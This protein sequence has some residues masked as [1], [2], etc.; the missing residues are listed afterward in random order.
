MWIHRKR[1]KSAEMTLQRHLIALWF[2]LKDA[3]HPGTDSFKGTVH[4]TIMNQT[5]F[6]TK[7]SAI[8][9]HVTNNNER[10]LS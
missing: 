1:V 10:I 4:L 2:S 6:G 9:G 5:Y 7:K 3:E 8:K